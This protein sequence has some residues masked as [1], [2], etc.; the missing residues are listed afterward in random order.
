MKNLYE[1]NGDV[2]TIFL[3]HKFKGILTTIIDTEDLPKV[4]SYDVN[5]VSNQCSGNKDEFYVVAYVYKGKR[6]IKKLQLH[7]IIIDCPDEMVPDHINHITN[8]NRKCNLRVATLQQNQQNKKGASKASTSGYRNVYWL[9]REK[10][11]RA[12]IK[13]NKKS[14][15]EKTFKDKED[16]N[17]YAKYLRKTY[18]EFATS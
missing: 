1:I 9:S 7:R 5:W 13:I 8:D 10:R 15:H 4:S 16:A 3:K 14:M 12:C 18:M 2:T 6:F 17:R 11:W